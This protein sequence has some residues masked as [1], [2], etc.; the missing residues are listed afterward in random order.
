MVGQRQSAA[1][2][3]DGLLQ[4]YPG[5]QR[6]NPAHCA[7][8]GRLLVA[9]APGYFL[10]RFGA[11][12]LAEVFWPRFCEAPGC[13][14]FVWV[15]AGEAVGYAAGTNDRRHFLR[16]VLRGAP[17]AFV[18]AATMAAVRT[19][20]VLWEGVELLRRLGAEGKA[21]GP[22]AEL[23]ALGMAPRHCRP[24]VGP[25]GGAIS[26]ALVLMRAAAAHLAE[27]GAP[28]FRLYCTTRNRLASRFYRELGFVE[29]HR[30]RMFGVEKICYERST[31]F[32]D[33]HP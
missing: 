14:G 5:L 27:S 1:E 21:G 33:P 23:L 8:L 15:D 32:V 13:F 3:P 28:S 4:Q 18:R 26:P 10:S 19:P 31:V 11:R 25:S 6:L 12:Y 9:L 20:I 16:Q 24:V 22:E 2:S 29:R 17:W 7:S 30:F